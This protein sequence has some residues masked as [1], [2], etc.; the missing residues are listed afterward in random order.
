[1]GNDDRL[2]DKDILGMLKARLEAA[3]FP[4]VAMTNYAELGSGRVFQRVVNDG[5]WAT[6]LAGAL[7]SFRNYSFVS[8]ILMLRERAQ[9]L[10]TDKW[11]GSEMYQMAMGSRMVAAGGRLLGIGAV[12]VEK[13]IQLPG[14]MVDS[15]ADSRDAGVRW[16]D[17]WQARK[18]NPLARFSSTA[19][20]AVSPH[21]P[22][23]RARP[24]AMGILKQTLTRPYVFW[25]FEYKRVSGMQRAVGLAASMRPKFLLAGFPDDWQLRLRV[26]ALYSMVT[27]AV[28]LT[29]VR[30]FKWLEPRLHARAKKATWQ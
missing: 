27:L 12:C 2:A 8:G 9:I 21:C 22:A 7:S 30:F 1:M 19:W 4:E 15:Y 10:A 25:L 26:R 23:E 28:L 11:D 20:D 16:S 24:V 13:D 14:E 6:G 17:W 29:P 3:D 18:R 5:G